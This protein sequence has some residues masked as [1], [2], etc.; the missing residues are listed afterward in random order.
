MLHFVLIMNVAVWLSL[1][2]IQ[3]HHINFVNQL[4]A[5]ELEEQQVRLIRHLLVFKLEI[6]PPPM[7]LRCEAEATV[8]ITGFAFT[9]MDGQ[10]ECVIQCVSSFSGWFLGPISFLFFWVRMTTRVL[11]SPSGSS[12]RPKSVLWIF[13]LVSAND[14]R[15]VLDLC[16]YYLM[17]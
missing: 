4:W 13:C 12:S 6:F 9:W 5:Q 8:A 16:T 14:P 2:L 7:T 1:W 15:F 10:M 11:L 17:I 3:W